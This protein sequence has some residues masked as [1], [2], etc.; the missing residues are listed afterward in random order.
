MISRWKL[1]S[2]GIALVSATALTTGLTTAYL[3][4]PAAL[5]RAESGGR[6]AAGGQVGAEP[7]A[8]GQA[9]ARSGV[10]SAR[11]YAVATPVPGP[12]TASAART[13]SSVTTAPQVGTTAPAPIEGPATVGSVLPEPPTPAA[14]TPVEHPAAVGSV[15]ADCAT[16]GQRAWRIAKPGLLG[17]LVG[18]G[19]GA[20]GGAVADGGKGAGKGALIGGAA[21]AAVGSAYGAYN[22]KKDCGTIFGGNGL[23]EGPSTVSQGRS[24]TPQ[25]AL[26]DSPVPFQRGAARKS[27]A[28]S[29]YA[30]R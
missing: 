23:P 30:V 16:G 28:I 2:A 14:S 4:R 27:D 12:T 17:T 6:L 7:L 1:V 10:G 29:I 3:I 20:A 9:S 22:T 24:E 19:L 25:A 5:A 13:T 15:P 26:R 18:A 11:R 21:G 8:T